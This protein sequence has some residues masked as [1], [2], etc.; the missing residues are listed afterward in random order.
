M[1][2]LTYGILP[3]FLWS[4]IMPIMYLVSGAH[5]AVA[6]RTSSAVVTHECASTDPSLHQHVHT[7]AV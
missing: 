6:R 5:V 7:N 1:T 4:L 2:N 3:S